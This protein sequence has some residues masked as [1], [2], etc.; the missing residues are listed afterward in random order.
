MDLKDLVLFS[1]INNNNILIIK[2][3]VLYHL[4]IA[5]IT[6]QIILVLKMFFIFFECHFSAFRFDKFS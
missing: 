5:K 1:P 3:H 2:N 4:F 6:N